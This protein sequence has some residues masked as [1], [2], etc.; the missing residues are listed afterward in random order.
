MIEIKITEAIAAQAKAGNWM[1]V[2]FPMALNGSYKLGTTTL[3]DNVLDVTTDL[4]NAALSTEIKTVMRGQSYENTVTADAGYEVSKVT[5]TMGGT[6]VA[7]AYDAAT[8]KISIAA[9]T[10]DLKIQVETAPIDVNNLLVNGSFNQGE[11][12]WG[13]NAN[14]TAGSVKDGVLVISATKT[15]GDAIFYQSM[16]L[17][18]GIYRLTFDGKGTA[19]TYRP[20]L[21]IG[22]NQWNKDY[23]E[24]F[25]KNFGFGEEWKTAAV[26]FTVPASAADAN[27][28]LAP[29]YVALWT[30]NKSYAPETE[31]QLD[32]FVVCKLLSVT[33][34]LS[35][36]ALSTE[37]TT[38]SLGQ[39]YVNTVT[40]SAGYQISKV[41]VTMGGTE[42][43][44]AYDAATGKISIAAVTGD[45]K[46]QVETAPIDV[47]NLLVNGGFDQGNAN[48]ANNGIAPAA[49]IANGVMT[50]AAG[51]TS[52]GDARTY[53]VMQ[54]A[55]GTYQISFD[56]KGTPSA[57]RP[58]VGVSK[59]YWTNDY[60]QYMLYNYNLSDSQWTTITET[61]TVPA[62]AA[63]ATTG[64]APVYV[65]V[66]NS[67]GSYAPAKEMQL[68]NFAVRKMLKVTTNL[69]NAAL[70]DKITTVAQ[71]LVYENTVIAGEGFEVTKVTVTMGGTEVANAY[72]AA[73]GKISIA[74]VTGDLKIQVETA[75]IDVNNLLVNGGFDQGNANWANNGIAP[76]ATIANGVM[77]LAAGKTSSGDARTYNVMQLAPGTYQISFDAKGIPTEYR[78]YVGVS[79]N[80]WT[81]DY[82]QYFMHQ[83]GLSD[84][85]WTT[86]TEIFTIPESAVDTATGLAP[87]YVTVWNSNGSYA[88]ETEMYFDNFEVYKCFDVTLHNSEGKEATGLAEYTIPNADGAVNILCV[89]NGEVYMKEANCRDGL[90]IRQGR[91][92]NTAKTIVCLPNKVVVSLT[93]DTQSAL[94]DDIDV[95][96]Q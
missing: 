70:S 20:L 89:E 74:A 76:A 48:W 94:P 39:S 30:S 79:K 12:G 41:T 67:N 81:N 65:T 27:T 59:N 38:L 58:Y 77:T 54:L 53:N 26:T 57:Y 64:L 18:P 2:T 33:A 3:M 22:F 40:A 43:T 87:V 44:N 28:G 13:K 42:V 52:S 1:L 85:E 51:K 29:V 49:T 73:T 90:C 72:D 15:N 24:H 91:M 84:S 93:G 7:N 96:I 55:P 71:G 4:H 75:P 37:I 88:P 50:L 6:E 47:N 5:V 14:F 19:N 68:D 92:K 11:N 23:G 35:N 69:S 80:Y 32:N 36:A 25:L 8:G 45:L 82:G 31:M 21:Y 61:F 34:N 60:G 83:Y 78:P 46:I 56:A 86:V 95:I 66:W 17:A 63:D 9:V 10:G 62:G 16:N